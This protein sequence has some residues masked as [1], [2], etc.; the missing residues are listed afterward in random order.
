MSAPA[1]PVVRPVLVAAFDDVADRIRAVEGE[2]AR[3]L[4]AVWVAEHGPRCR[5][6][7]EAMVFVNQAYHMLN[8]AIN[9]ITKTGVPYIEDALVQMAA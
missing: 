4:P 9:G 8:M 6:L 5:N 7:K 1:P 3:E 2:I